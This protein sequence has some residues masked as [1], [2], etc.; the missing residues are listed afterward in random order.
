MHLDEPCAGMSPAPGVVPDLD[1]SFRPTE[2]AMR[3][4]A[5]IHVP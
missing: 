1:E 5:V 4:P 3:Q 2:A